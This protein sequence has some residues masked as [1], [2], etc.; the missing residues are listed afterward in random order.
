MRYYVWWIRGAQ[1]AE[2]ASLSIQSVQRVDRFSAERRIVVA[3]DDPDGGAHWGALLPAE[4]RGIRFL[5]LESG[6]PAM[7]ANLDAQIAALALGSAGDEFLFLDADTLLTR[8]FEWSVNEDTKTRP[9]DRTLNSDIYVTYRDHVNGDTDFARAQPYNYGVLGATHNDLTLEAFFWIRAR[10]LRMSQKNQQWYGNQLAL[11]ELIG[12][13]AP[14]KTVRMS[15][16][17]SDPGRA[18]HV[19]CLP[20]DVWNYSPDAE[21][22]D[23]SARNVLH[24]KGGRKD[25][26]RHYAQR[27]AA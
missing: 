24:L 22:E 10:I 20:C 13:P 2:L 5:A 11:A 17:L 4:G 14:Q 12:L 15:W 23:I 3:T 9:N 25:L 16:S 8:P 7:V 6:R 19:A 18:L 26:M 1:H 21:G 27:L